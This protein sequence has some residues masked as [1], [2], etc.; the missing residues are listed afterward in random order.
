MKKKNYKESNIKE[1]Q[2]GINEAIKRQKREEKKNAKE[3]K[4]NIIISS[5]NK[6]V[7]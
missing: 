7:D 6:N 4:T 2:D 3:K 5:N 1:S